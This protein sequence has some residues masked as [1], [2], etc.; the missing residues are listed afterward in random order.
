MTPIK[1]ILFLSSR[2]TGWLSGI[3]VLLA[4][5]N[6]IWLPLPFAFSM[7]LLIVGVLFW[8]I[9]LSSVGDEGEELHVGA[10]TERG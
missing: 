2:T 8:G 7:L 10:C 6:A 4:F 5:L 9:F 3:C 1:S